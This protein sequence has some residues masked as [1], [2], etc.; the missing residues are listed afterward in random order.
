MKF[1]IA[2][3]LSALSVSCACAQEQ[4]EIRENPEMESAKRA[5]YVAPSIVYPKYINVAD[6]RIDLKG[7]DWSRLVS[8][9]RGA[10]SAR[11]TIVH[12]GDSH[13]QAD[14]G[15]AVTRTLLGQHYGSAGRSLIVPFKLAG[16]N[17]PVDYV[18]SSEIPMAQARLLKTPWGTRMGFT[19]IGITPEAEETP[20]LITAREPFDSVAIYFSGPSL[21]LLDPLVAQSDSAGVLTFALPDT[22]S[23]LNITLG[24]A[25]HPTIHGINLINGD[26]G[27]A[28][29][30]IGNN[31]ATFG[32]Y[33]MIPGF[34]NDI[35]RFEPSLIILSLGTNEAYNKITADEFKQEARLL[36]T[37]LQRTCP[38]AEILLTTP[39]ETQN[40]HVRKTGKRRKRR[41]VTTY[42]INA[43]VKAMRDAII[44]VAEEMNLPV[45][46]FY[47]VAGGSGA[48]NKWFAD[49]YLNRD[50]IHLTRAGY[51]LQ[52]HLF[53]EALENAFNN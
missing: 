5:A 32:T 6:N 14:M 18:I 39:S 10:D 4:S 7:H 1:Y 15:T 22:T 30:V 17:E 36:I 8:Q 38:N 47:K 51:T 43:K 25:S 34:A 13:L 53:T 21:S 33:N 20:M 52:G 35:A 42:T 12:I 3:A 2:M 41:T 19:G 31:G 50:H 29:H 48:S 9:L 11:V 24:T 26:A 16:T 44:E 23:A 40:K 27:V 49:E 28:Y 45:Y 37:D 46:D